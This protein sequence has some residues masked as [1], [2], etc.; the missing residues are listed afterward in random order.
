M[1]SKLIRIG[2]SR[3]VRLPKALIEDAGLTDELEIEVVNGSVVIHA[4]HEPRRGWA[5]A[6]EA[7]AGE[8]DDLGE[9]DAT[10]G[11]FDGAWR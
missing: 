6:A 2:N 4:A 10:T 3:G 5:K 9:W 7:C 8:A 1:Y 11:D